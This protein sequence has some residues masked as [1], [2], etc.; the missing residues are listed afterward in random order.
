[1][2]KENMDITNNNKRNSTK[3]GYM[4]K[5]DLSLD[6]LSDAG[7]AELSEITQQS[8]TELTKGKKKNSWK[9]LTQELF[10]KVITKERLDLSKQNE[11]IL[12][13]NQKLLSTVIDNN[14]DINT[15]RKFVAVFDLRDSEYPQVQVMNGQLVCDINN[16]KAPCIL[17]IVSLKLDDGKNSDEEETISIPSGEQEIA[18]VELENNNIV[19]KEKP[20]NEWLGEFKGVVKQGNGLFSSLEKCWKDCKKRKSFQ[21]NN[22]LYEVKERAK[23]GTTKVRNCKYVAELWV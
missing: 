16:T 8:Y 17:L 20:T 14:G 15:S 21:Y 9:F 19:K 12:K 11:E 10:K 7:F 13:N 2:S 6:N 18:F 22:K 4:K 23:A 5:I 3:I 1:M